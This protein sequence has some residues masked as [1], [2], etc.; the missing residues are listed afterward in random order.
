MVLAMANNGYVPF[1]PAEEGRAA[2][3][4]LSQPIL[5]LFFKLPVV[6]ILA[7]VAS[8]LSDPERP[9]DEPSSTSPHLF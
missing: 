1:Y 9:L 6:Q 7:F 2:S 4:I 5:N 8:A 3:E